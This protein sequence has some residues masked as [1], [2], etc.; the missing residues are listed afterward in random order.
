MEAMADP[1]VAPYLHLSLQHG[2]NLILKR[3]KRRHSREQAIALTERLRALR[4]DIAF[5]ADLIAGFP[6]E[7]KAQFENSLRL[8]EDCGLSFLHAFPY[9]PRP[10][11]PGGEDAASG[12]TR[13]QGTR[14]ALACGGR[15]GALPAFCA[16]CG[17]GA[18]S[19]HRTRS[20]RAPSGFH[21]SPSVCTCGESGQIL[22]VRISSHDGKQ[23]LGKPLT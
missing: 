12:K 16:A 22:P 6:T 20:C 3:M 2:D 5:G 17:R 11:T 10:G 7:T 23:L 14:G 4:P 15:S 1:R 18:R 19:A 9:S 21:A 8:V 13:D